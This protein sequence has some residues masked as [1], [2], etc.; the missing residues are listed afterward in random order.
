VKIKLLKP[1]NAPN[2]C[3]LILGQ[4]QTKKGNKLRF[5]NAITEANSVFIQTDVD[6]V[7]IAVCFG[8]S[9]ESEQTALNYLDDHIGTVIDDPGFF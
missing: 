9:P 7:G 8:W 3:F 4:V 6:T 2:S 5:P 1:D